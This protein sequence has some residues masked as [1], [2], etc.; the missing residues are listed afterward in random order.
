MADHVDTD[1]ARCTSSPRQMP[2]EGQVLDI[3]PVG[4]TTLYSMVK[5]GRFPKGTYISPN[6]RVWFADDVARWQAAIGE[7]QLFNPNRAVTKAA[8]CASHS[9]TQPMLAFAKAQA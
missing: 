7:S 2:N 8:P 5:A 1:S 3:V 9:R 4:R 6:R